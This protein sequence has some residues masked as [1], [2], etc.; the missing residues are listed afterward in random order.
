MQFEIQVINSV[1]V[2]SLPFASFN[3]VKAYNSMSKTSQSKFYADLVQSFIKIVDKKAVYYYN[4]IS[5]LWTSIDDM[6]Y[7]NFVTDF[8]DESS[9]KLKNIKRDINA[10]YEGDLKTIN[11][12]IGLF[13]NKVYVN[14]IIDRSYSRLYDSAFLA[15]LDNVRYYFP[16]QK[17]KMINCKTLELYDRT[18]SDYFSYE[19]PVDFIDGPTP[20]ADRFF[21]EVMP[22]ETSR[23]YL[24][25]VLGYTLTT[26]TCARVFL[27]GMEK[28]LMQNHLLPD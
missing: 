26:E 27:F 3:D 20:N 21:N 17:G 22:N 4:T 18:E 14:D 12:L 2:N 13:D 16:I 5:K 6:V 24:R 25:T 10:E 23:E 19:S 9:K 7:Y 28:D 8:F 1:M 11:T 15:N